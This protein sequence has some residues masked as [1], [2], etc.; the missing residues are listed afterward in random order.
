MQLLKR[1]HRLTTRTRIIVIRPINAESNRFRRRA[2]ILCMSIRVRCD[3][4]QPV[5]TCRDRARALY[6]R[7]LKRRAVTK[8]LLC[9]YFLFGYFWRLAT[10][11]PE[12]NF[13]HYLAAI[14]FVYSTNFSYHWRKLWL[15]AGLQHYSFPSDIKKRRDYYWIFPR[16]LIE[17][18]LRFRN[19]QPNF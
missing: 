15:I 1:Y 9:I 4:R 3:H 6:S 5:V 11:F 8:R 17:V 2:R 7:P 14:I 13:G 10:L 19:S 12:F 16:S 18:A